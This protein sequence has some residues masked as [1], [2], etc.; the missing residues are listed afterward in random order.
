MSAVDFTLESFLSGINGKIINVPYY[1]YVTEPEN[2]QIATRRLT[3][4]FLPDKPPL[5]AIHAH[6]EWLILNGFL[7]LMTGFTYALPFSTRIWILKALQCLLLSQRLVMWG[8]V[9]KWKE[10]WYWIR[11]WM[12]IYSG[13]SKSFETTISNRHRKYRGPLVTF[14]NFEPVRLIAAIIPRALLKLCADSSHSIADDAPQA[15]LTAIRGFLTCCFSWSPASHQINAYL[16]I[17]L[18]KPVIYKI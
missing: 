10:M 9:V 1:L 18:F 4:R 12:R 17:V 16:F 11:K 8:G 14:R 3:L 6:W 5:I 15:Y 13:K 7:F 2:I